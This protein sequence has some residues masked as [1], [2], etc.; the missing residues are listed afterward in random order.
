MGSVQQYDLFFVNNSMGGGKACVYQDAGNIICGDGSP[1]ALAWMICGANPGVQIDFKWH[2][3]YD[4]AWFNAT[5]PATQQIKTADVNAGTSVVLALDQYGYSF[6][7]GT[8]PPVPGKLSLLGDYTIPSVNNVLLGIG[9]SGAGTFAFP[10]QPNVS[11]GFSPVADTSLSYWL[12]FGGDF[13][14][15]RPVGQVVPSI[16]PICVRFPAGVFAMTVTL[17]ASNILRL[18]P[19]PPPNAALASAPSSVKIVYRAGQDG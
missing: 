2:V 6:V 16:K 4:C 19:G 17:D 18:V 12:A 15:N 7:S 3:E 1:S 14:R 11:H 9:M 10:A 8:V 13:Q 5:A